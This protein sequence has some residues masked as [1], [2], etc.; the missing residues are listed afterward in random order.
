[1]KFTSFLHAPFPKY[2]DE[3]ILGST[4][5]TS[6]SEN[7]NRRTTGDPREERQTNGAKKVQF[8]SRY[9]TA[10]F[11]LRFKIGL[12]AETAG[13]TKTTALGSQKGE[14][15]SENACRRQFFRRLAT[16]LR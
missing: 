12:V 13:G 11:Q 2:L 5:L 4:P 7:A 10:Q 1:V 16:K 14:F 6:R 3:P 8:P 9:A 15:G